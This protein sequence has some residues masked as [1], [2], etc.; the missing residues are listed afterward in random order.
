M[1][2]LQTSYSCGWWTQ[3]PMVSGSTPAQH[4]FGLQSLWFQHF[5]NFWKNAIIYNLNLVILATKTVISPIFRN[6]AI[7]CKLGHRLKVYCDCDYFL[8]ICLFLLRVEPMMVIV[9]FCSYGDL[10][11]YLRHCRGVEDK[12]YQD[13][14]KVP[15]EKLGSRDLLS[16]AI[17]TARGMAHLAG[18]KVEAILIWKNCIYFSKKRLL[19]ALTHFFCQ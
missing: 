2:G 12:Y 16:F 1:R 15:I 13:L 17:Q 19:C 3:A 18:M 6:F 11:S 8:K 14:Y 5:P 10:Q 4:S 9:E 7:A